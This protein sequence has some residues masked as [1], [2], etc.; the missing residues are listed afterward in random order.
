MMGK[1]AKPFF[2]GY[3][4]VPS[5]FYGADLLC[6]STFFDDNLT[7]RI[8]LTLILMLIGW[9]TFS[10]L[11]AKTLPAMSAGALTVGTM[12]GLWHFFVFYMLVG[13]YWVWQT[14][15]VPK[16]ILTANDLRYIGFSLINPFLNLDL[17][18]CDGAL[19]AVLLLSLLFIFKLM[20]PNFLERRKR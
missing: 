5:V 12:I 10:I 7:D 4:V 18:Q 8:L 3:I 19:A 9:G 13:S 6:Q 20:Q 2:L 16:T 15:P 11:R 14:V 17:L 1:H